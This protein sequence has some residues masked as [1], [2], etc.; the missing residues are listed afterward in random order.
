MP[1]A[2][3]KMAKSAR[4]HQPKG[5]AARARF[6]E[7]AT[8][9]LD[10]RSYHQ[11]RITDLAQEAGVA[12]GLFY[13]YFDSMDS[14]IGELVDEFI[15]RYEAV[16]EIE[17][18]VAKGDWF[19][20]ILSHYRLVIDTY[21][22]YPGLVRCLRDIGGQNPVLRERWQHS[23]HKQLH[24]LIDA[25]PH[26]FGAHLSQPQAEMLV[27]GLGSVGEQMVWGYFIDRDPQFTRL[28]L[29]REQMA[30]WLTAIYYRGL[31]ACNPPAE[32]LRHA[33]ILLNLEKKPT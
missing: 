10:T 15:A 24:W 8:R 14:L 5:Q 1:K 30:E 29:D 23:Y 28:N 17:K 2:A 3:N 22:E 19:G 4:S 21:A 9:L 7:A 6:K 18:G 31:F 32:K 27:Y 11:L 20:R 12:N 16:D 26:V 13:H 33:D 25:L